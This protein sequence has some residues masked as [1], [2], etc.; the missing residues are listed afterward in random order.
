M[1]ATAGLSPCNNNE[2]LVPGGTNKLWPTNQTGHNLEKKYL[3]NELPIV[4]GGCH[5]RPIASH[6]CADRVTMG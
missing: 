5:R 3:K 1:A 6:S 4:P 2:R